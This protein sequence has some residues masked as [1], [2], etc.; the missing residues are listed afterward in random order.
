MTLH[1]P[2]VTGAGDVEGPP[3]LLGVVPRL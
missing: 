2:A 1:E 3:H